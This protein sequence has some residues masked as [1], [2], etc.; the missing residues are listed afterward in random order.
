M[1]TRETA[2][3]QIRHD[4]SSEYTHGDIVANIPQVESII[5]SIYNSFEQRLCDN[6]TFDYCGCSVQDSILQVNPNAT[7][8]TFGCNSFEPCK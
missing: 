7:F 6:C 8:T 5:D 2:K 4:E 1:I 3:Q